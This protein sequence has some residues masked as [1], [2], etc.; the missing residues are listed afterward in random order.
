MLMKRFTSKILMT[1]MALLISAGVINAADVTWTGGGDGGSWDDASNWDTGIPT[2]SDVAVFSISATI[3]AG[4]ATAVPISITGGTLTIATGVTVEATGDGTKLVAPISIPGAT[5]ALVVNGTLNATSNYSGGAYKNAADGID[6]TGSD[7]T[8]TV[9]GSLTVSGE[10]WRGLDANSLNGLLTVASGGTF[11]VGTGCHQ[12][13]LLIKGGFDVIN[14]GTIELTQATIYDGVGELIALPSGAMFTNNAGAVL[15]LTNNTATATS[16]N[17]NVKNSD[18]SLINYGT[19]TID[20]SADNVDSFQGIFT[21]H[22]GASFTTNGDLELIAGSAITNA[23]IISVGGNLTGTGTMTVNSGGSLVT[24]GTVTGG[25]TFERTTS[26]ADGRY[27]F[28]GSPVVSDASITGA[29]LGSHVYSYNEVAGYDGD[30]GLSRWVDASSTQLVAGH[31]YT[32]ANQGTISFTGTPNSGSVVVAGLTKTTTGTSNASDQGWHLLSNP[33][34]AAIDLAL[35]LAG[36]SDIASS[37][38]IWEDG[39]SDAAR[40]TN[41][42]YITASSIATV[43]GSAKDFEGY[44]GS[45]QGF[46]VQANSD[47]VDVTFTEAMRVTGN[48]A[49]ANFFREGKESTLGVKLALND[50]TNSFTNELFVGLLADATVGVDRKYDAAKLMGNQDLQFYSLIDDARFA[51]QGL[52]FEA[53]VSTELAFNLGRDAEME[54]EVLELNGLQADLTMLLTDNLTGEVYDLSEERSIKFSASKG[55]DQNRFTLTYASAEVL[56]SKLVSEQPVYRFDNNSSLNVNF[57]Q[58]LTV[59]AFMV[60]DLS[61]KV[62]IERGSFDNSVS[63]LVIPVSG[64]GFNIVKIVTSE[65]VFTRKFNF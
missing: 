6:L 3:T 39:G 20:G 59:E 34:P 62:I 41:S 2:A 44:I 1:A 15:N 53:G 16:V 24:S 51:I 52:P 58:T 33:Y 42:D 26:F 46:F 40:R 47:N 38:S 18:A 22:S 9:A 60:Y 23:G 13:N 10:F 27:S 11:T 65:G 30:N 50:L 7:A 61:G 36:N 8:I 5:A 4:N 25:H 54:I 43:N 48:N 17:I 64:K 32:Q 14:N 49:D 31:G 29:N 56:A 35:F 45:M 21:N 28:V 12:Q 55:T 37:I 63:E 57:G 19:I